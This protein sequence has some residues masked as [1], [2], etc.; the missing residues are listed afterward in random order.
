MDFDRI[1]AARPK[2]FLGYSDNTNFSFLLPTLCDT[3]AFYGPCAGEFGMEPWDPA[4]QD[5]YDLLTGKNLTVHGYER[6][7]KD[8]LKDALHPLAPYNLTEPTVLRFYG[9]DGAPVSG[10]FEKAPIV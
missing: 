10:R 9:W 7:E 6:W 3:A 1:R 8:E 5:C 4:V 2:W